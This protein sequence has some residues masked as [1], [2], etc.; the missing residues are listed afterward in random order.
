MMEHA[1]ADR[2]NGSNGSFCCA[3]RLM[4]VWHRSLLFNAFILIENLKRAG[5]KLTGSVV[6]HKL[7]LL[8]KLR[9]YHRDVLPDAVFAF[10][11]RA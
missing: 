9:L 2:D 11:F 10:R 3:I 5:C 6:S 1:A 7:D 8:A 4:C